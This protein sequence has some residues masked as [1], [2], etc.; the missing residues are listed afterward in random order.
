MPYRPGKSLLPKILRELG[1]DPVDVYSRESVDMSRH[2][3]SDYYTGRK[4]MSAP[5]LYLFSIELGVPMESLCEWEY[6]EK[7]KRKRRRS[8]TE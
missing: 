7:P 5:T 4:K 1:L 8:S 3:F 2:Q 6:Y